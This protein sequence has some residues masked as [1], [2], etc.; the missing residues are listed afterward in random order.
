ML[1]KYHYLNCIFV[2]LL[3]FPFTC[4]ITIYQTEVVEDN[5]V[6]VA[7]ALVNVTQEL[8]NPSPED[9]ENI[10]DT[11]TNIVNVGVITPEVIVYIFV[12]PSKLRS[13]GN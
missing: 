6:N 7:D 12:I 13:K 11:F 3:E 9:I 8:M 5:I 2:N 4:F 1:I 10:A